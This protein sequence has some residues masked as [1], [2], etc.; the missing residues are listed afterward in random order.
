MDFTPLDGIVDVLSANNLH[1]LLTLS[2][3]PDWSRSSP[4]ESGPPDNFDDFAAFAS[5]V[6]SSASSRSTACALRDALRA[7]L[8]AA[9]GQRSRNNGITWLRRKFR[10]KPESALLGSSIQRSPCAIA[11]A[12]NC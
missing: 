11:W 4:V 1:V 12:C 9:C 10:L 2:N 7:R 5:A 8:A 3:A 6:A